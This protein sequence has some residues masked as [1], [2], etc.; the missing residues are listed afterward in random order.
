ML[1]LFYFALTVTFL[2]IHQ[3]YNMLKWS[4]WDTGYTWQ[5]G[6]IHMKSPLQYESLD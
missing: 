5:E 3:L 2:A 4:N 1:L 6:R